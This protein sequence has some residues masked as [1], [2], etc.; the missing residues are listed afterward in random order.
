MTPVTLKRRRVQFVAPLV[1]QLLAISVGCAPQGPATPGKF[2]PNSGS[3]RS[4]SSQSGVP[5]SNINGT[6]QPAI[7]DPI[8]A[9]IDGVQIRRS[10]LMEPLVESYGLTVL[11]QITQLQMA[12]DEASRSGIVL[13]SA[14]V[15]AER[16]R[17]FSQ[18]FPDV[19][20]TQYDGLVD[21][22]LSQQRLTRTEFAI[23]I[24]TNAYLR[25]LGRPM[26]ANRISDTNLEETFNTMYGQRV[27]VRHI[28]VSNMQEI[29][30]AQR[31]LAT[32][33]SFAAVARSMSRSP[34][35]QNLG[36]EMPPFA[37]TTAGIN[38]AFAE[39]AFSLQPGEISNP[40]LTEG[41]YHLIKLEEKL[42]P[43]TQKFEDVKDSI[44][45]ELE[46]RGLQ[47]AVKLQRQQLAQRALR[48]LRIEDPVIA[49]QF[50]G[51]LAAANQQGVDR[52]TVLRDLERKRQ[53]EAATS[54]PAPEPVLPPIPTP[55]P[56]AAP[57]AQPA[58]IPTAT[59]P[60]T[61]P[62]TSPATSPATHPG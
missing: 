44:R 23:V 55:N 59:S 20:P 26:I 40:V 42:A 15:Q 61:S 32:G 58:V 29:G 18:I 47:E 35:T 45:A 2:S 5:Q 17:T 28:A 11:L 12:R 22:L 1:L 36:G 38:A 51:K 60:T 16:D 8:I 52:Q 39:T 31:R 25:A 62:T 57:E 13:T 10:Q 41:L 56:I 4:G 9:R 7:V 34:L 3:N 21:Q 54:K 48:N 19:D 43:R 46:D 49:R 50:D 53:D 30:E 37:R 27:R 6:T 24:E 33:E 14:D